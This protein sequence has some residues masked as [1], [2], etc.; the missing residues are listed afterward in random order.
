MALDSGRVLSILSL[1]SMLRGTGDGNPEVNA[2][3]A[4]Q[5]VG[6]EKAGSEIVFKEA[7]VRKTGKNLQCC[8]IICTRKSTNRCGSHQ[9][10]E[11]NSG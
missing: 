8:V 4:V 9:G 11:G 2:A 10:G 3:D 6:E 1:I 7:G 5:E